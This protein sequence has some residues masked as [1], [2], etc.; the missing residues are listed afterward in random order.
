VVGYDG[1]VQAFH[2]HFTRDA[3]QRL[4]CGLDRGL[5]ELPDPSRAEMDAKVAEARS[6]VRTLRGIP[7]DGLSFDK[8]LDL[9]LARLLLEAEIHDLTFTFNGRPTSAQRPTAGVDIGD[10]LFRMFALDPRPP[11]D[12]LSDITGCVEWIPAPLGRL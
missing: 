5:D 12:R 10:L 3:T 1:F 9:D 11:G 2:A 4:F 8:D 6:L 7:R